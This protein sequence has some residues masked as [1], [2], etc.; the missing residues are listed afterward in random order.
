MD[1]EA[2]KAAEALEA[3]E[4]KKAEEASKN[5]NAEAQ[6]AEQERIDKIVSERLKRDREKQQKEF[7]EKLKTEL[8]ERDRLAKLSAEEKAAEESKKREQEN[9]SRERDIILRENRADARE[10]LQEKNIS[11]D[12]VDFVVDV[13]ADKTKENIENLEKAFLKAVEIG[14]AEKMKG[15]TPEDKSKPSTQTT[16]SG[17]TVL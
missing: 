5:Q 13:D 7:D 16:Y 12:L 14:V 6:K 17:S 9:S 3:E 11:T 2:K 10:L 4:A 1:D 8:A 15:K